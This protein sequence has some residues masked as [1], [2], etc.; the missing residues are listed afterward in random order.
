VDGNEHDQVVN[1]PEPVQ[2]QVQESRGRRTVAATPKIALRIAKPPLSFEE[3]GYRFQ[4]ASIEENERLSLPDRL[5]RARPATIDSKTVSIE[6]DQRPSIPGPSLSSKTSDYRFQDR[7]YRTRPA[8]IDS[9]TVSIAENG[10][11]SIPKS[12]SV[13]QDERLS[14]SR[15]RSSRKTSGFRFQERGH[16]GK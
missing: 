15:A 14:I 11:L 2:V 6:Q 4:T 13:E 3:G 16:R 12:V 5:Y 9:K 8:T 10:R 7:L 1:E